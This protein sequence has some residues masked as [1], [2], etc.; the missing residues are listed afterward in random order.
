MVKEE[1]NWLV[2][3]NTF[4]SRIAKWAA[5]LHYW[6]HLRKRETLGETGWATQIIYREKISQEQYRFL[7]CSWHEWIYQVSDIF[8]GVKHGHI[9]QLTHQVEFYGLRKKGMWKTTR[10]NSNALEH[11]KQ[12]FWWWQNRHLA[13][14]WWWQRIALSLGVLAAGHTNWGSICRTTPQYGISQ[15]AKGK[16]KKMRNKR[17]KNPSQKCP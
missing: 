13:S 10:K 1:K 15:K 14:Y 8:W 2:L 12:Q 17:R 11:Q 6:A 5:N 7:K 3:E 4:V 16:H 9:D